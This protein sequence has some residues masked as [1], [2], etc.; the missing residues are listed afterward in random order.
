MVTVS[1]DLTA[2]QAQPVTRVISPITALNAISARQVSS[3]EFQFLFS[4]DIAANSILKF[5]F[6]SFRLPS[7]S[8]PLS[9]VIEAALVDALGN[10]FAPSSSGSYPA[11]FAK[12]ISGSS[13]N[14]SSSVANSPDVSVT[15]TVF[16]STPIIT[17]IRLSGL[18][19]VAFSGSTA[20]RRRL[21]E[22]IACSNL[23]YTGQGSPSASYTAQDGELTVTFPGGSAFVVN[24]A[25]PSVCRI[26]GF[27]NPAAAVASP[28]VMVTTYDQFLAGHGVQSGVVFPPIKCAAGYSQNV[29][30]SSVSC[31]ACPKGT[32]SDTPGSS[33]CAYCPAGTYSSIEAATSSLACS[34]CPLGTFSNSTG[35]TNISTCTQCLPGTKSS[36]LGSLECDAC[37]S[38]TYSESLG[39]QACDKCRAGSFS[40]E[41]GATSK[42]SCSLC[43][44]GTYSVAG[45]EFCTRCPP[46][47]GS[48]EGDSECFKCPEG[49]FS[50]YGECLQCPSILYSLTEGA[51][52]ISDCSGI[53]VDIGENQVAFNIGILILIMYILSFFFVPAW[54]AK[55]TVMR[56]SLT[57]NFEDRLKQKKSKRTANK[58]RTTWFERISNKLSKSS[59]S[60]VVN[61]AAIEKRFFEVGDSVM[62]DGHV[63]DGVIG[64][65]EST[66]V[67]YEQDADE[68]GDFV[69]FIKMD[70]NFMPVLQTL[71]AAA[72]GKSGEE[73]PVLID[74]SN[75]SCRCQ[76]LEVPQ[77]H[78]RMPIFGFQ[79]GR[80]ELVRQISACFQLLLLSFFPAVDTIT[81]LVY[82]LSQKFFNYYLFAASLLCITAQF[83][84]FVVRLKKRSVFEAFKQRKVE[85]T[86]L[87]G[88]SWWPKWASPDSLPVFLTL[89]LPFYFVYHVVFPVVW[90]LVG[91]VIYSFQLFPISRI[92]NRWLYMF[93]YSFAV[94]KDSY[95]ARFDTCDAIILPMVQE[96]KVEET[97]LESVPQLIIQLVNGY[98]LGEIAEMPVFALFSISLSVLSLSSTVWCYAY[99]NLVRCR[100]IRDAPSSLSLYNYKLSGVKEGMFSFGKPSR[101]V[102]EI[103]M[104]ERDKMLSVTIADSVLNEDSTNQCPDLDVQISSLPQKSR[105]A[106]ES[107][108]EV[109]SSEQVH[110]EAELN[111]AR[112]VIMQLEAERLRVADEHKRMKE[113]LLRL[114][115]SSA[116]SAAVASSVA[117]AFT[118]LQDQSHDSVP[119]I[120]HL[121]HR[122]CVLTRD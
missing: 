47:T 3:R 97:I 53:R 122:Y 85:L 88:L 99:W 78:A 27:R 30:G 41:S 104:A 115:V 59:D 4:V 19:F 45:S 93:V 91:Y 54:S 49:T 31:A 40:M 42:A 7:V 51:S 46:G 8:S 44:A 64:T 12:T 70:A 100:P 75:Q 121:H 5:S 50:T 118:G 29:T 112:A 81:D 98:L 25:L 18:G 105:A 96:G 32:F 16:A 117:D 67:Y 74:S 103:E 106:R 79:L 116:H 60:N 84:V 1:G 82:I 22:G 39:L 71:S 95:R 62:W 69:V 63:S 15:V 76:L 14:L 48:K 80:W 20:G 61:H 35:A 9:D 21:Q 28:G 52:T 87:K 56:F 83:W 72:E 10:V 120:L 57:A 89:I 58:R 110:L 86:F 73:K 111:E 26:S 55:D 13:V 11:I 43:A 107:E 92:S 17:M 37:P 38:G 113:L 23:N 109:A 34:L 2:L 66:S 94:E 77:S 119:L 108:I 65:V 33:R 114:S 90:F 36:A 6:E 102:T 101:D 24:A 68:F